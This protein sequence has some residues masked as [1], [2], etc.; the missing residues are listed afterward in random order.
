MSYKQLENGKYEISRWELISLLWAEQK[1]NALECGWVDN[2]E[3]YWIEEWKNVDEVEVDFL[4]E[5]NW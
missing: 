2:W 5:N 1:L 3:W 4:N